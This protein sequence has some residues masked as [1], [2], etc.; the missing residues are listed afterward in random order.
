MN[1]KNIK[2]TI[3]ADLNSSERNL[4]NPE[5]RTNA[6]ESIE[7]LLKELILSN[8]QLLLKLEKDVVVKEL[9]K[10]N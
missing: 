2:S 3:L 9:A 5:I 4:T 6:L 1:W 7:G 10:M 8:P